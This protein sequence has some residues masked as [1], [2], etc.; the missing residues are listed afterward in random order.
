MIY[1]KQHNFLYLK[2]RKVG[3][4][5]TEI[6]LSQIMPE[7]AVVT[8]VF[9]LDDR[10]KARNYDGFYNHISYLE[11][12][13]II[14]LSNA[15]SCVVVR[16]PFDSV[17]SDFFLQLDYTGLK[18]S[19]TGNYKDLVEPYFNDSI[20]KNWLRSSKNIY[21]INNDICVTK[22]LKY[23][24]GI[25]SQLNNILNPIGLNLTLDVNQK[26]HRPKNIT[27][28]DIFDQKYLDLI[29]KEWSWE[30]DNLGYDYD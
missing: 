11:V 17:L 14:D 29:K 4:S 5:S 27:Y 2:N 21:T 15:Y 6:C 9:P 12:S 26:A 18:K 8:P 22:I 24:D 13:K 3:G 19:Y 7:N 10:H 23:E 25:E 30:F 1:S 16:H 20:R 28:K